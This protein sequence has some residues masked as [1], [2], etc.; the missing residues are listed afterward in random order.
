MLT[1]PFEITSL[2]GTLAAGGHLHISLSDADG[3]VIGGHLVG[4]DVI[5]TTAEVWCF[6]LAI[7]MFLVLI[8]VL[9]LHYTLTVAK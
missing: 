2:M 8:V 6:V 1:G 7:Q 3:H 9:F 5:H 4:D